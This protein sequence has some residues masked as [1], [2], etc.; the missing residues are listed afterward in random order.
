LE[1][2]T[3]VW[4]AYPDRFPVFDLLLFEAFFGRTEDIG[5][6]EVLCRLAGQ[7]GLD[8]AACS[9]VLREGTYR[10]RVLAEYHEAVGLGIRGIPA[11]VLPGRSPIVGA[12]LYPDL[13]GAV[14]A[15]LR[16]AGT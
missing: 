6:P 11:V 13:R 9:E 10:D 7:C 3:W 2:A 8:V 4:D 14:D 15:V 16:E 1:A 5:D 12:V